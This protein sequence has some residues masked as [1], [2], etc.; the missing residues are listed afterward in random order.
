MP[1]LPPL[2]LPPG[3]TESQVNC[4]AAG[5]S[6]HV[7][8]CGFKQDEKRPL[9]LLLHGFPE[10][11]F[12]WRK[13][14]VPLAGAGY[15]VVAVDQR[16]Y[17][18]T[19]GWDNSS[20]EKTDMSQ[21]TVTAL[22][23]DIVVLVSA[24]GYEAVT[25][26][27]G[28][29]FGSVSASMCA[30]MRPDIFKSVVMMS[31]PFKGVPSLP[32]DVAH[33]APQAVDDSA[34]AVDVHKELAALDPPRKHYLL[35]NST[36]P[37]NSDWCNPP[38]GL[39]TFLRGYFYLKSADWAGN[40]PH[41]LKAWSASELAQL[42][43]YYIMP[44][45][46][47]MPEAVAEDMKGEDASKTTRWLSDA[48]LEVYVQEWSRTGFQ[49]GLNWYRSQT[50][51]SRAADIYLFAGKKI[52]VPAVFISGA[53]DWGNYQTPGSIENFPVNCSDF[54]GVELVEGAGHWPQQEQPEEVVGRILSF[55][56][57]L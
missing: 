36:A 49:G 1:S 23:R 22:V 51:P 33:R 39:N 20:F 52:D 5:L 6:F 14:M 35:Y 50:D 53:Q 3:I 29:D 12:S 41:P 10:L 15:Y 40:K 2:P 37:A 24:L 44:L 47:T 7:L 25:C 9:V 18:R 13:V 11:A 28:H 4:P 54:R 26:V 8:E 56:R 43:N 31:H 21:F 19:T 42:P 48:D 38:Q 45:H 55:L 30:L 17:G 34:P 32:F 57:N 27:V 46:A 16:G